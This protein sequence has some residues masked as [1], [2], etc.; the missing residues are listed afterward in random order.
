MPDIIP[1]DV[2]LFGKL[3]LSM[4]GKRYAGVETIQKTCT[5]I[6]EG[7]CIDNLKKIVWRASWPCKSPFSL[8]ETILNKIKKFC[9]FNKFI[10]SLVIK[11]SL[12]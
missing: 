9:W 8:E 4:K 5:D 3:H 1:C 12:F 11:S 6:F 7:I 10:L 2:Y